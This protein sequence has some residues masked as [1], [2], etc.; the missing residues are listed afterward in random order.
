MIGIDPEVRTDVFSVVSG[1]EFIGRSHRLVDLIH[2]PEGQYD[3][4]LRATFK[5][6]DL[7]V[8]WGRGFFPGVGTSRFGISGEGDEVSLDGEGDFEGDGAKTVQAEIGT[9]S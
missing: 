8:D 1:A 5:G 2:V 3:S 9:G 4:A 7:S 6:E